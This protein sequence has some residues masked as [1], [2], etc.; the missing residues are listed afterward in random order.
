M[1][2]DMPEPP[3]RKRFQIHL[4]T[5]VVMMFVA[6]ALVWANVLGRKVDREGAAF[7][8]GE[9]PPGRR[10]TFSEFKKQEEWNSWAG[11]DQNDYGWPVTAVATTRWKR[12]DPDKPSPQYEEYR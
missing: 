5:A 9:F 1:R 3:R 11:A 2:S 7:S 6:G 12:V 4:S 10:M 8:N